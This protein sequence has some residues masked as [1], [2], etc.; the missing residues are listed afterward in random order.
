MVRAKI[1]VVGGAGYVG[2]AACAWLIDRGHQVWVLDD[3]TT[4]HRELVLKGVKGFV[5]GKVGDRDTLRSLLRHEKFDCVMHF[6]ARSLVSES[7]QKPKE[8][9]EN[10][11]LQTQS[12]LEEMLDHGVRKFI[13][14]STC[15]IF[16]DPGTARIH[17]QLPKKPIN[18]YGETKLQAEQV[19]EKLANERGLQAIALRYFNAAGAEPKIRV[20]EWHDPESH[21][22]PR[23]F[24][25][26]LNHQPVEMYGMDY[27]TPDG[28]CIRDYIHV[29]DLAAAHE[30]AMLRLFEPARGDSGRFEFFNLGSENGF[31]VR[32]VIEACRRVTGL[33]IA[34]VEKDRRP[35]D[36]PMLVADSALAK[37]ELGFTTRFS[38]DDII[39]TAWLWERKRR[40]MLKKAV[41]LDRDGTLNEDPGYL[42]HPDQMKILPGV[43]EALA[44]LKK[45]G[46]S[47]VVVSNQSGVSRGLIPPDALPQIHARM[48]Q[49][50]SP[51]GVK[52]DRYA[53]CLHRP[54]EN[55]ACRKPKP[56]LLQDSASELGLDFARSYMVGDK[57]ADFLA[58]KAS[59]V[60]ASIL[61][62]TGEGRN[63]EAKLSDHPGEQRPDV[64]LD[65]L[66]AAADWILSQE[67]EAH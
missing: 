11:V 24:Q 26:A 25:A 66:P 45:A 28:S 50:L 48:D 18:P 16:G 40:G 15:A 37:R 34:V 21:L 41:F 67:N 35:G 55:C 9:F 59:G 56:K 4:G 65:S 30:Q 47:L 8:Y 57:P 53:L 52:I 43:G 29:S 14:S 62:R 42:S 10:N 64:I 49:L 58:G 61:V 46:F 1:L 27:P 5:Q 31:S 38:L 20:G 7:V 33:S 44:K 54:E 13:F 51:Y 12:L 6:A 17:E 19:I 3:L 36:P 60:R 39:A 23:I 32:Q 63:T 2:S 22:I